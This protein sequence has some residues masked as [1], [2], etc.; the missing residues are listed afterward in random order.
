MLEKATIFTIKLYLAIL[1]TLGFEHVVTTN[2]WVSFA[3]TISIF[4][5]LDYLIHLE[6]KQNENI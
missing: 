5:T 4:A 1:A 3:F 2:G 6:R